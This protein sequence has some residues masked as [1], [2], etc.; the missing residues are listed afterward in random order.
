MRPAARGEGEKSSKAEDSDT[1]LRIIRR[2]N[3]LVSQPFIYM[4]VHVGGGAIYNSNGRGFNT[5]V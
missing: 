4:C 1:K 3:L 5:R 2:L